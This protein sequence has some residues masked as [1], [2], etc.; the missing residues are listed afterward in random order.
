[1]N[2]KD[3]IKNLES[4]LIKSSLD[5]QRLLISL[6]TRKE[7]INRLKELEERHRVKPECPNCP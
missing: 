6:M 1:M 7:K 4:T 3:R 5:P 2:I